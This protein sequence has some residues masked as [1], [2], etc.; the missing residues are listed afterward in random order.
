MNYF[1]LDIP[2]TKPVFTL[3]FA[4]IYKGCDGIVE[5]K[6]SKEAL[7]QKFKYFNQRNNELSITNELFI[8]DNYFFV[9]LWN[10]S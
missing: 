4:I 10:C 3:N 2:E 8:H 5:I 9:L 7:L 1:N 6:T